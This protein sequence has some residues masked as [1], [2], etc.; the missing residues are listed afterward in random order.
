MLIATTGGYENPAV[1]S[2]DP[3]TFWPIMFS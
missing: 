2:L 3:A 1:L